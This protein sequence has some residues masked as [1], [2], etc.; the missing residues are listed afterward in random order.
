MD[1][2]L[3]E[4]FNAKTSNEKDI[5]C[6]KAT[7]G[8]KIRYYRNLRGYTLRY[9]ADLLG[10]TDAT[11]CRYERNERKIPTDSLVDIAKILNISI[12]DLIM[13]EEDNSKNKVN[14]KEYILNI[15]KKHNKSYLFEKLNDTELE[16]LEKQIYDQTEMVLLRFWYERETKKDILK[17]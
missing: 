7:I 12:N 5:K 3:S 14:E 4:R 8:E 6:N 16:N 2:L 11:I 1:I 9:V 15:L 10:T 13:S 17:K